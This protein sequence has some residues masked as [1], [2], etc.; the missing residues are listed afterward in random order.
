MKKK[1]TFI[2]G[3]QLC[4][5]IVTA[6]SF[7]TYTQNEVKPVSAYVFNKDLKVNQKITATDIKEVTVPQS[8]ITKDFALDPKEFVDKFVGTDVYAGA[9][10]YNKQIKNE[11]ELDPFES[12]D[13]TKHRKISLP[14]SYVEGFGGN[15]KRGDSVDLVF[16]GTGKK[17]DESGLEQNFQYSK[18]FLQD[19]L[20][21]NV[22]TSDGYQFVD[23]SQ[24]NL[25]EKSKSG[26]Q[27]DTSASSDELAVVTLSVTLD[28]VEEITARMNAGKIRL[29][30][31][32]D[33]NE[34][35]ETLGFVL[36]DYSK[37]YAAS[38][39]A[40]TGRATINSKQ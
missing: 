20:V 34:S 10:V 15:L 35:Y 1:R 24:A 27:I 14:I 32:F 25:H 16:T 33:T 36:G 3:L 22:T 6:F 11:G 21:Y 30:S 26:E 8:A 4:L 12:M 18:A 9:F 28:Q 23:H 13:L 31:R 17:K 7:M 37:V 29:V 38:A 5:L 19:V 2:L 39:N 40:E